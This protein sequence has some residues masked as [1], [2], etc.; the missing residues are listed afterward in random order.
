MPDT[1]AL[2]YA[3]VVAYLDPLGDLHTLSIPEDCTELAQRYGWVV[4]VRDSDVFRLDSTNVKERDK[5]T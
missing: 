4:V 1:C 2:R 3:M 5:K